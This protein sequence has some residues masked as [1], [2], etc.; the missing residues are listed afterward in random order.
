MYVRFASYQQRTAALLGI[1]MLLAAPAVAAAAESVTVQILVIRATK[2]NTNTSKELKPLAAG[3][4]KRFKYTGYKLINK[5]A[6]KVEIG[7]SWKKSLT[8]AYSATLTPT[9]VSARDV[10]LKLEVR[11]RKGKKE[12]KI[13]SLTFKI[14]KGKSYLQG[15]WDLGGGDVLIIAV[16]AR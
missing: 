5:S 14:A 7:K 6:K 9:A 12:Q 13:S 10:T 1:L 16:S 2:T 8:G 15:G 4:K 11:R 3:L